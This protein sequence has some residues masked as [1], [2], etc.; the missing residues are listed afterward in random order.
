[1]RDSGKDG[2]WIINGG[3]HIPADTKPENYQALLIQF[4]NMVVILMVLLS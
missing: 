4:W 1:M 2:G 3:G